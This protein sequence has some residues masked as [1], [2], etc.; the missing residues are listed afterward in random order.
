LVRSQY[1]WKT[2]TVILPGVNRIPEAAE[3]GKSALSPPKKLPPSKVESAE[4]SMTGA[5]NRII[6][7]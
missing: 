3:I 6:S 1:E 5:E 2:V 4:I 7:H